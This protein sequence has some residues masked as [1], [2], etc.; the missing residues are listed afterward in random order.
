MKLPP[1]VVLVVQFKGVFIMKTD[2]LTKIRMVK[3]HIEEYVT[4]EKLKEKYQIGVEHIK[5]MI[6]L[7][8]RHGEGVFSD[9]IQKYSREMKLDAIKRV[10]EGESQRQVAI[11]IGL[12]EPTVLRDWLRKYKVG[13]E[14]EIKDSYSRSH[15]LL[16][17]DRLDKIAVDSLKDRNEYLEAENEYLKKLYSLILEKK[18]QSKKG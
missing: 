6:A 18:K 5:Y 17:E 4:L 2:K 12:P 10:Y 7:Y 8:K 14:K 1:K 3:E 16:H 9:D 13:G 11:D 15:Y